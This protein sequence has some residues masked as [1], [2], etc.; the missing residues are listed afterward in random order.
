MELGQHFTA[1]LYV[2]LLLLDICTHMFFLR[3]C[4]LRWMRVDLYSFINSFSQQIFM[5]QVNVRYSSRHWEL[6]DIMELTF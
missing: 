4:A 3:L 1:R 5:K 6:S 2:S